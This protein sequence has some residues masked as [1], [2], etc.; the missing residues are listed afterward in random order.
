M[1]ELLHNSLIVRLLLACAG[2]VGRWWQ[3]SALRR[4]LAW[5][6]GAY[7]VS[8]T[9]RLWLEWGN[10]AD[11]AA[12]SRYRRIMA[13]LRRGLEGLGD[14]FRQGLVWR[15]LQGL[16]RMYLR[17]SANSRILSL[18]N[19]LS[20][21]QWLLVAFAW[22]LPI[23]FVI[24]DTLGW[25]ALAAVWE[26]AFMALA[27]AVVLWR[28][29]L[30]R[31]RSLGRETA[32]D[33]WLLLFLA[34]G[35][36]LMSFN[37]P[38][39]QV[40]VAGYRIVVQY[41][42][43]YFIV[44][45]LLEDDRDLKVLLASFGL[46]LLFLSLHGIYQYAIGVPIP[47]SWTSSTEAGVRTRVFSLTGSPNI[48]GSLLVLLAPLAAAGL[49]FFRDVRAKIGCLAL[50]LASMLALLFTFSRG[51]WLGM[52]L[53]VALFSIFVD[54]R[55]I[56]L[57]ATAAAAILALI[58]SITSRITFLF[59]TEY[60]ELTELGGRAFRWT[61]GLKLL[62]ESNPWLGY[63]LGMFGGAV[64]MN[65]KLLDETED[66]YYFYMD[67]Y[68]LKTLVE[69]GYLGMIFY[70]LLLAAVIYVGLK[71]IQQSGTP[72]FGLSGDPL[73]RAEGNMRLWA[74]GIFCGLS[75]VLLHCYFENIFEEP[76][77]SSYFWGLAAALVYLGFFRQQPDGT[78]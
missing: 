39:P 52:M 69:M 49:Y 29:A 17:L 16:S 54:G 42:L 61:T 55:L 77:M 41:M 4:A 28:I 18:V 67:N 31:S 66:F 53:A 45:R 14:L 36:F 27:V 50:V 34:V 23:E 38:Y 26:E 65:N 57:M 59:S 72:L 19:R 63:G 62:H 3:Y 43:W 20:A 32:L 12:D 47:E 70:V 15:A 76:Y 2:T 44:L 40:A 58:P 74:V 60:A 78:D 7:A 30:R 68:Y 48:L 6:R 35:F 25:L 11:A 46:L 5:L 73:V 33:A 1:S 51:A 22:Y 75:G 8:C 71:A 21:R 10:G 37:R 9:R 13:G 64:A 24:R 56:A